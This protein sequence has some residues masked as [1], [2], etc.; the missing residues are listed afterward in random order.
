[1]G[2]FC[3][4]LNQH[5]SIFQFSVSESTGVVYFVCNLRTGE[6]VLKAECKTHIEWYSEM[7]DI[8]Y[9]GTGCRQWAIN[10]V[11]KIQFAQN[12]WTKYWTFSGVID[13]DKQFFVCLSNLNGGPAVACL[14]MWILH[15]TSMLQWTR[16]YQWD[17]SC[18]AAANNDDDEDDMGL[19]Q[20]SR[21]Q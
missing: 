1:M 11:G 7:V 4:P 18:V 17:W 12:F 15:Y 5:N 13:S 3:F 8:T 20:K 21:V 2:Q 9:S 16:I 19:C 10:L 6:F 14:T